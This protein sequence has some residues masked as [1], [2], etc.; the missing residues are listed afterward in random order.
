M[1]A[2]RELKTLAKALLAIVASYGMPNTRLHE[3]TIHN[4][5]EKRDRKMLKA[6]AH[7]LDRNTPVTLISNVILIQRRL[8]VPYLRETAARDIAAC[9][10]V[11]NSLRN[12][13]DHSEKDTL[14]IYRL[15]I[16]RPMLAL[17][18]IRIIDQHGLAKADLIMRKLETMMASGGE[19]R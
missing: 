6:F 8:R 18:V 11:R 4:A 16:S 9:S 10:K 19:P 14:E 1:N 2:D 12:A 5:V 3:R 17:P 13:Q 7:H 15:V